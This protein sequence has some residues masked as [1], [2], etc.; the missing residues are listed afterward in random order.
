MQHGFLDRYAELNSPL[1]RIEPRV[2]TGVLLFSLFVTAFLNIDEFYSLQILF[3]VS[4]L[5]LL[6]SKVPFTAYLK[7]LLIIFPPITALSLVYSFS[8]GLFDV[9]IFL[10]YLIKAISCFTY[11][12]IL[13]STTRFE[14]LLKALRFYK[15]PLFLLSILSFFY[16]FVFVIQDELERMLKARDSRMARFNRSQELKAAFNMV[17]MLILRSFE[18]SERIYRS[19]LARNYRQ[20]NLLKISFNKPKLKDTIFALLLLTTIFLV[21]TGL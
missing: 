13:V 2:K 12:F 4:L 17:S 5:L 16:R 8:S 6:V 18:R 1:H 3:L 7:R 14:T 20:E 9:K 10:F 21:V 11:V 15:V 19:M